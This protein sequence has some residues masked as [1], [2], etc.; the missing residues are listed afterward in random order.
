MELTILAFGQIADITGR[1][2]W[3]LSGIKDTDELKKFLH[4]EFPSLSSVHYRLAVNRRLVQD[5]IPLSQG[6]TVALLPPF[7]GG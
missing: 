3:Q 2:T 1:T 4:S 7:S 5:N 6:D